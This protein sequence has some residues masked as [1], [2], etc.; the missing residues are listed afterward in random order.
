MRLGTHMIGI[1]IT[2]IYVVTSITFAPSILPR[3]GS[4][5]T[6]VAVSLL[7]YLRE[8]YPV[9]HA[10]TRNTVNKQHPFTIMAVGGS[11]AQGYDDPNLNGYL[12]RALRRVST[13][14]NMP[15]TFINK[16]K[17]G[18]IPTMLAPY[19]DPLLHTIAP[20]VV[21]LA[22]GLLNSIARKV[23]EA[24]FQRTIQ[25]EVTMALH[26]GADVW[27]V[28][29]P[30]TTAT[31]VGHDVQLEAAYIKREIAGAQAVHSTHVYVLD[32]TN[33]MKTY[34]VDHH[35]SYKTL[36]SNN[37]HMNQAGHVLAGQIL[38][39]AILRRAKSLGLP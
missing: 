8:P 25:S 16:A 22:W 32:L 6:K 39:K 4:A 38:A 34:L 27:I 26:E 20:N 15:I 30:V 10:A 12:A 33:A 23:P 17:S 21:I 18:E 35:E 14:L 31:Y 24:M 13:A 9:F 28:T 11:S 5:P 37:W 3:A 1:S 19:Y 7:S 36:Q 29:P 2:V